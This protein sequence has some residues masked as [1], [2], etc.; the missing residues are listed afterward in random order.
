M[1]S[2]VTENYIA[3]PS[4]SIVP[5]MSDR[6]FRTASFAPILPVCL[7][8]RRPARTHEIVTSSII[9]LA[10]IS[11]RNTKDAVMARGHVRF[12]SDNIVM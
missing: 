2:T 5:S 1:V 7:I 6:G 9:F 8:D 4:L 12:C 10:L 11:M 3:V